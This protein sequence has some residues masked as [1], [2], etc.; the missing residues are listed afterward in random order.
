[1]YLIL[2]L[3][4]QLKC[5]RI[6]RSDIGML[7][8]T[9]M[10]AT[11]MLD[12]WLISHYNT[13]H[14]TYR[15]SSEHALP[16][17][18]RSGGARDLHRRTQAIKRQHASAKTQLGGRLLMTTEATQGHAVVTPEQLEKVRSRIGV[19]FLPDVYFNTQATRDTVRHFCEGL[20]D[21]NP[22]YCSPSYAAK[23]AYG[24]V[25]APPE[26]LYSIYWP[27]GNGGT[28]AGIHGW[29]SG[30]DWEWYQP[31]LEG[32][33]FS[34]VVKLLSIEEKPSRM[35][36]RIWI[37]TDETIFRNQ[38]NQIIAKAKGWTTRAE[39]RAAGSVGK[40]KNIER[41]SYTAEEMAKIIGD[42]DKEVIR[43]AEPR[44]WEDV[45]VGEELP[46]VIKGPLSVRDM[47]AW[48]MGA[49]S[50]FM[51]AHSYFYRYLKK[52]PKVGMVDNG[53][54]EIDVPELVHM[55]DTRANEIG[56]PGAYDYGCQRMSWLS[57]LLTNWAGDDG[58]ITRMYG[59]VRRFNVVGDTHWIKG[60]VVGKRVQDGEYVVDLEIWG[61]NQRN[62]ITAPG[63]ATI[64]LPSREAGTW[65]VKQR[66]AKMRIR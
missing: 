66:L 25:V 63:K 9:Q 16:A 53:T 18:P 2:E 26:F 65:P 7:S 38:K 56:I 1:M 30:N 34:V 3:D 44:F 45:Q 42:Y 55:Q 23:T 37:T 11:R 17:T 64:A 62:E 33:E 39:R 59:E 19:E 36:G 51:K 8:R 40:Y 35:A 50:P 12:R 21:S 58:F 29:H 54:G 46:S 57:N 60:K 32:D 13:T 41:A 15:S 61:E 49:G 24:R 4:G 47:N 5:V 52:H 28:M 22:L 31:I 48:L 10:S 27:R 14:R 20:G 43:G 6:E